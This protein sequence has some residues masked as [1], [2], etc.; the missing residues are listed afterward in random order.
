VSDEVRAPLNGMQA[1]PQVL[2]TLCW[3]ACFRM[4][5]T[6]KGLDPA[7]IWEKLKAGG[8]DVDAA[9]ERGLLPKDNLKAAKALGMNAFGFG[10]PLSA[11]DLK[12]PLGSSPVWTCGQWNSSNKHVVVLI[13]ASDRWVEHYDPW[14]VGTPE[15]AYSAK[16]MPTEFF[17][18]GDGKEIP[19]MDRVFQF[20]PLIYWKS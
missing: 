9:K 5:Y 18:H 8:I 19:G 15:D 12:R 17:L 11:Y 16:K 20:Y 1:Q 7:T 10:Q 3:Y 4:L 13:A 6:W 2:A 14:W